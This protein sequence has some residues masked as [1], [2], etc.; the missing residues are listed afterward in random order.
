MALVVRPERMGPTRGVFH[1]Q[2]E[3]G[4]PRAEAEFVLEPQAAPRRT[5]PAP[6]ATPVRV[7]PPVPETV[8]AESPVEQPAPPAGETV[9]VAPR[10]SRLY[11]VLFAV[12]WCIAV[13][14]AVFA[15]RSYWMPQPPAPPAR[16]QEDPRVRELTRQVQDLK[17]ALEAEQ[18]RSAEQKK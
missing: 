17:A 3:D 1:V 2:A 5:P 13:A 10:S 14:S 16:A 6:A 12:A 8:P 15:F 11:W 7:E 9:L 18:K 4:S